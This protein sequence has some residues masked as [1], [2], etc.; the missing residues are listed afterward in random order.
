[1]YEGANVFWNTESEKSDLENAKVKQEEIDAIKKH[2]LIDRRKMK[3]ESELDG[4]LIMLCFIFDINYPKTFEI[5]DKE[6]IIQSTFS[7]FNFKNEETK[8]KMEEIKREL[9]KYIKENKG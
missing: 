1:M 2:T 4:M 7:R 6:N 9:N 3:R 5:I 8:E